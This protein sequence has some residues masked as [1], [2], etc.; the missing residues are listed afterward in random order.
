[1]LAYLQTTFT[2]FQLITQYSTCAH[3]FLIH[4]LYKHKQ[5]PFTFTFFDH[6]GMKTQICLFACRGIQLWYAM[7]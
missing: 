4:Q 1:M 3:I 5:N 7:N 2:F 6:L